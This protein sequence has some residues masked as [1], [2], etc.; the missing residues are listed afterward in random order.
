MKLTPAGGEVKK[1]ERVP[2]PPAYSAQ[3]VDRAEP[4]ADAA[5]GRFD[6]TD[7]NR[8]KAPNELI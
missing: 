3:W 5:F 1:G 6:Q 4:G 8:E 2:E 7:K